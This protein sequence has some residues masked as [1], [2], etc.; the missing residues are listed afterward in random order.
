MNNVEF[1]GTMLTKGTRYAK[2]QMMS[3]TT[4]TPFHQNA[5]Q[6]KNNL[7][8]MKALNMPATRIAVFEAA[9]EALEA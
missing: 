3:G 1:V 6:I 7:K 5:E 9:L 8:Q 4:P 2:F